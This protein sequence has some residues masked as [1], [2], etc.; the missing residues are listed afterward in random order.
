MLNDEIEKK[1]QLEK[2]NK[3]PA[4]RSNPQFESW[5]WD[6]LIKTKLKKIMKLNP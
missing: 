1:G 4:I 2:E 5:D 3:T 6:N